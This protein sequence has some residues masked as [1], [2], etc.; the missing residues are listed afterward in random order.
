MKN[1]NKLLQNNGNILWITGA[2]I[3]AV[4]CFG[5][6]IY[7]HYSQDTFRLA[8]EQ[9]MSFKDFAKMN[10]MTCIDS[11]RYS[12]GVLWL[13]SKYLGIWTPDA[14]IGWSI[15]S[16]GLVSLNI[17]YCFSV[18]RQYFSDKLQFICFGAVVIIFICPCFAD[19]FQFVECAPFYLLGVLLCNIG[20][21]KLFRKKHLTGI[22][23]LVIS[24]GFYQ[25][26]LSFFVL[27]YIL[28]LMLEI[29]SD[30]YEEN[31]IFG[32]YI[33]GILKGIAVYL[34]LVTVNVLT[35][36]IFADDIPRADFNVMKN[37]EIVWKSQKSI[38]IMDSIGGGGYTMFASTSQQ[39]LRL[40]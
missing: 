24:V 37:L 35:M 10:F 6:Y 31:K 19:W 33:K 23:L 15:V 7:P 13:L 8:R 25:V 39:W 26:I 34:L 3:V 38:W 27:F 9:F 18:L 40:L 32:N 14:V 29:E 21:N 20:I 5:T 2:V 30:L 1:T 12:L 4:M 22:I 11:G 28:R 17:I 36:K 16:V